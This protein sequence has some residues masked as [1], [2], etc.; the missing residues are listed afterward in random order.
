MFEIKNLEKTLLA[1]SNHKTARVGT[2]RS[3]TKDFKKIDYY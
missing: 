2:F 1:I 3:D